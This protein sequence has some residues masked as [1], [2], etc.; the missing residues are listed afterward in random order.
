MS[1]VY[2]VFAL[3]LLML[4]SACATCAILFPIFRKPKTVT[5]GVTSKD[6]IY[7]WYSEASLVSSTATSIT[8]VYSRDYSCK[9]EKNYFLASA[10]LAVAGAGLGGLACMFMACWINAGRRAAL[11]VVSLIL[12]FFAFA[13]CVV[14]VSLT[15]YLYVNAQCKDETP[16]KMTFKDDNYKLVEGFI[17]MAVAAG[18][19]LIMFV[20]E[21]IGVCC[22]CCCGGENYDDVSRDFSRQD[23]KSSRETEEDY[24]R[25]SSRSGSYRR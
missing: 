15:A 20:V 21:I 13:C 19:F 22:T 18:G 8:R 11:G 2:R 24:T 5:A 9:P 6:T 17:L 1:C 14:V 12:T 3:I 10:A 4:L 7:Y 25:G 23:S 16:S